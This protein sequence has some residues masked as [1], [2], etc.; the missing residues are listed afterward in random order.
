MT[1]INKETHQ[2]VYPKKP[3]PIW[4]YIFHSSSDPAY[5]A[6]H[7]HRG[8]E[9]SY[10][11]MGQINDFQIEQRHYHTNP[12]QIVVVNT[13]EIH[14]ITDYLEANHAAITINFPF[15]YVERLYPDIN[16]Q[17]IDINNYDSLTECQKTAYHHLQGLLN[18]FYHTGLEE[19]SPFKNVALQSLISQIL[20]TLII[21]FTKEAPKIS[22]INKRKIYATNRLQFITQYVNEHYLEQIGLNE[23]AQECN[24]SK[25]YLSR[26]FKKYMDMTIEDYINNVRAQRALGML[27]DP[28]KNLTTIS[29]ECGFTSLRS[30]NRAL[31]RLYGK[32]A[33]QIR[34]KFNR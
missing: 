20:A 29:Y 32:S 34:R 27:N 3:F 5:I 8:I 25:S 2:V 30:L 19:N 6:P 11:V 10:T 1:S 9:L 21:Y 16:H 7:W 17:V 24:L 4:Y 31:K 26:F 18:N 28:E 33:S 12:G 13:Q 22:Q 23:L 14:T 15:H